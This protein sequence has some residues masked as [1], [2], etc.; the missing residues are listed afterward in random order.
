MKYKEPGFI[1]YRY[2][3]HATENDKINEKNISTEA[4]Q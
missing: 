1:N 3:F 2:V 4:L